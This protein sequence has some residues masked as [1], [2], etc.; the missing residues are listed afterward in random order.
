MKY[1]IPR[2]P[3]RSKLPPP[4]PNYC[5]DTLVEKAAREFQDGVE[6]F[7]AGEAEERFYV[8][9]VLDQQDASKPELDT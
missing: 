5:A 8:R 9:L 2:G 7:R 4:D 3:G 6:K 1:V